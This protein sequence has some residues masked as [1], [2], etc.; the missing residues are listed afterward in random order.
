MCLIKDYVLERNSLEDFKILH[1][2]LVI[3]QK[4]LK[5][6]NTRGNDVSSFS[7]VQV[8]KLIILYRLPG[9]HC[10]FVIV[11]KA[12]EAR[13]LFYLTPP[14]LQGS[15]RGKHKKRTQYAF[16]CMKM[17]KKGNRLYGLAESHFI[18]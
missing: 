2:E 10:S 17:E 16:M 8:V 12:V 13:P 1:K 15:Q 9:L 6:R 18:C 11:E 5:L 3:G 7:C 4:H 14:L